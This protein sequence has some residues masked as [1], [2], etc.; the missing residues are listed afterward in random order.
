MVFVH[1]YSLL[2]IAIFLFIWKTY[3]EQTC[4]KKTIIHCEPRMARSLFRCPTTAL[5]DSIFYHAKLNGS[6]YVPKLT[7]IFVSLQSVL[8]HINSVGRY[9]CFCCGDQFRVLLFS[10]SINVASTGNSIAPRLAFQ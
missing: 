5:P 2:F 3:S 6:H 10:C 8:D 7:T 4:S 9:F 1:N